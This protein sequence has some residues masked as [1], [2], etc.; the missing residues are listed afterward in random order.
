MPSKPKKKKVEVDGTIK[1]YNY[2]KA[3]PQLKI[4]NITKYHQRMI[5]CTGS[6]MQPV[7]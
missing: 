5:I 7:S 2:I 3:L 6:S 4:T 1:T